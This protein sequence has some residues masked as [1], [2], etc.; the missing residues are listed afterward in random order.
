M[1]RTDIAVVGGGIIGCLIARE[2]TDRDPGASVMILERDA[3]GSGASRRSAGLHFPR[4]ATERVRRMSAYSQDYYEALL[5]ADP[6]LPIHRVAM[7]VLSDE[8][9]AHHVQEV[10]LDQ[11]KLE[12]SD[13]SPARLT[14]MPAQVA[15]WNGDGCQYA[16]V[17]ALTQALAR[18]LRPRAGIREGVAVTALEPSEDGY[19]LGLGTGESITAGSVVIAPGPWLSA[20]A[21][22]SYV[23]PLGAR[24][25]KV[26]ALHVEQPPAP[27]DG[28]IVFHDEDAFLLPLHERAHWLFSY[29]CQ[30]WDV[31]PDRLV[32]GLSASELSEARS[33]LHRWSPALAEQVTGGRVFCDAYSENREP[34]VR[35]LDDRG[36]L[37]FAGAA[38]GSGYRLGPAIAAEVADL[39]HASCDIISDRGNQT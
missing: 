3:V 4:G 19:V 37:V 34:L 7:S 15:V 20:P 14:G 11:A 12:R 35:A 23:A 30:D 38:N 21:W 24:V 5:D 22:R 39:L 9:N 18:T 25:K 16:Y 1:T 17:A 32:D 33:V 29:T 27:E 31:E 13:R 6:D 2:L 10:Y 26:I 28:V 36:R 8:A